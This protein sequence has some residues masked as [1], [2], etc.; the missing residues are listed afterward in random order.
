M[1]ERKGR[2]VG[3]GGG[4]AVVEGHE[5]GVLHGVGRRGLG[6]H[7]PPAGGEFMGKLV[8]CVESLGIAMLGKIKCRKLLLLMLLVMV[9][10]RL[11]P[12]VA[13]GLRVVRVWRREHKLGRKLVRLRQERV[14]AVDG[15]RRPGD[16]GTVEGG[17]RH[18]QAGAEVVVEKLGELVVG[19]LRMHRLAASLRHRRMLRHHDKV[20]RVAML[21]GGHLV[22]ACQILTLDAVIHKQ[23]WNDFNPKKHG[24]Q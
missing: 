3:G 18:G 22:L 20:H 13:E 17:R 9:E 11:L 21:E 4:A 10:L 14:A 7:Q 15:A 19:V 6:E 1:V 12:S 24:C 5:G 23:T 16:E 2:G 8:H